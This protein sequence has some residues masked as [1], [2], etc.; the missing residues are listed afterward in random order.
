MYREVKMTGI[1]KTKLKNIHAALTK[2][3]LDGLI[4]SDFNDIKY[5]LGDF[6]CEGEATI[7][8]HK[9]GVLAVSRP[10]YENDAKK[11]YP[12]LKFIA[13][14]E[15]QHFEIIKQAKAL[16]FKAVAF[17]ETKEYYAQAKEYKK[18]G[19]KTVS[20][21]I[22]SVR[23][24]KTEQEIKIMKE[25]AQIAYGALLY[26]K[27]EIKA[28]VTERQIALKI[29]MFMRERGATA[30]SFIPLV[31]F[32]ANAANPHHFPDDTKLTK[33]TAVL[34]DFGCVYKNYCSDITRC[35]WYG[36]KVD[37]EFQ[38]ILDLAI[39][40]HDTVVKKARYGMTG[41]EI[42]SISRGVIEKAGYGKYFIHR[43]GHGIG[44]QDHE[45]ADISELNK[46]KIGLNYCFSVEP[47]IYLQGKFGVRYE[48]CFYMTKKGIKQIK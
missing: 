41:A 26:I 2:N 27:K 4:L 6:F 31:S 21:F 12:Q 15:K 3:K 8:I 42:D 19:F 47:G 13:L 45:L 43:T 22:N 36:D 38:K 48:D 9:K 11:A 34:L 1:D 25:A 28:G 16:K 23:A 44:M 37:P 35:F 5:L 24:T 30:M 29:E 10:L 33:N 32:G 20:N 17:D 14:E 18:A 40:A 46:N 7:L 39:L